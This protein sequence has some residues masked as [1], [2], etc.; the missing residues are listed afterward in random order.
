MYA[1]G[2]DA[3]L[4]GADEVYG[5]KDAHWLGAFGKAAFVGAAAADPGKVFDI[6][7]VIGLDGEQVW[8]AV[9]INKFGYIQCKSSTAA[10]VVAGFMAVEP[11]GGVGTDAFEEEKEAAIDTMFFYDE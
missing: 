6:G 3:Q 8:P 2:L 1:K 5:A 9:G 4:A 10:G 7:G 11:Y